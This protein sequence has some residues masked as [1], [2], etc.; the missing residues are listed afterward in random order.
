LRGADHLRRTLTTS[1]LAAR[2]TNE[3][4]GNPV[5]ELFEVAHV[6]LPRAGELPDERWMLALASG[7]DF[8]A[9]K[10]VVAALLAS[11]GCREALGSAELQVE[12]LDRRAAWLMLEG[13]KI[14]YVAEVSESGLEA[15]GLQRAATIAEVNVAALERAANLVPQQAPLSPFPAIGRDLNFVVDE[16]VRWADLAETVRKH[17]GEHLEGIAYRETYRDAKQLGAGKKSLLLSITLRSAS[18]TLTGEQADAV[19]DAIVAA[20]AKQHGAAL[21]A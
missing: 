13:E 17:A 19:R 18:G 14:G 12:F 15:A 21:R 2:Q 6:Y 8:F 16:G 7:R 4:I 10:G 5:A 11:L 9:V 1:L 20:C 3:A